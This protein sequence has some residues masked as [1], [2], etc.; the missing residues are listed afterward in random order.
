[1]LPYLLP[2]AYV[3]ELLASYR[4]NCQP[5]LAAMADYQQ[6]AYATHD[7]D[8]VEQRRIASG[9]TLVNRQTIVAD[10]LR[11]S[12]LDLTLDIWYAPNPSPLTLPRTIGEA[13]AER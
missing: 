13:C 8:D 2:D 10:G 1:M 3:L 4:H 9:Q 11:K 12:P 5:D 7:R 6:V